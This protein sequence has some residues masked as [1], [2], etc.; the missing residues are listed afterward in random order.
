MAKKNK[1]IA[2]IGGGSFG[3]AI[4]N[5]LAENG[6]LAY[7]W[8][9]NQVRADEIN[10]N[11]QNSAYLPGHV[12]HDSV[13]ATVDLGQAIAESDIVFMAV[14]S[15]SCREVARSAAPYFREG[16]I[17]VSTTKGIEPGSFELMSEVLSEEI[18][19]VKLGVMS[20]PNLAK[21]IAE[22]QMT[23]TVVAST[24]PGVVSSV[25]G[26]L[27]SATFR[28]Y[29]GEDMYGVELGGALKN[30]YA[31]MAG[32]AAAMNL[33]QN[34]IGMLLTRSLAEMSRFAVRKGANPMTF[35]GLA[36]V[37]DLIVTCSSPLSRNYRVGYELGQGKQL[38]EIV[39]S[40]G[41]VAEGVNT[42]KLVKQQADEL[43]IYMPLASGLYE[44]LYEH[45]TIKQVVGRLML[46]EQNTDVEFTLS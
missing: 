15:K 28:V 32:L 19:G 39:E 36:G 27:S 44:I 23:G 40:L 9:R 17:L 29:A 26:V 12:L 25:Q 13:V 2:V 11:H 35:L 41:Q 24:D 31:I 21:E 46:G 14:P 18:K 38:E 43:D 37:G 10:Q 22:G 5:I 33:G 30:I 1:T 34:T 45:K 3:T 42:L 7:L 16:T 20:G 8:L 4:A 6:H